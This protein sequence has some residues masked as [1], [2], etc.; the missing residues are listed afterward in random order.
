VQVYK[1]IATIATTPG[2][3][4]R[5]S[6]VCVNRDEQ[7]R[8]IFSVQFILDLPAACDD[9]CHV[10]KFA[11]N[12]KLRGTSELAKKLVG[13][14]GSW[15]NKTFNAAGVSSRLAGPNQCCA[16]IGST[17]PTTYV[18][19]RF[20]IKLLIK[21][22]NRAAGGSVV[23]EAMQP[24]RMQRRLPYYMRCSRLQVQKV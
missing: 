11:C 4:V 5:I 22:T 19:I 14:C 7:A 15:V 12:T 16:S 6:Q 24:R 18:A 9:A 20:S 10:K 13:V 21:G 1:H 3:E 2:C 8:S 23:Q 17:I